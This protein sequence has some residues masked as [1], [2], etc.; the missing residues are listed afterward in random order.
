MNGPFPQRSVTPTAPTLRR[1]AAPLAQP[2]TRVL[3]PSRAPTQLSLFAGAHLGQPNRVRSAS[4]PVLR[5]S[6]S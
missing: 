5:T 6:T 1:N 3:Q 2:A 4:T